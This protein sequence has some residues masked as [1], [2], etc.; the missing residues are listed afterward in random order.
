[1]V[2][3]ASA[4]LI[5][6]CAAT[7]NPN[8]THLPQTK[9]AATSSPETLPPSEE[10]VPAA[11]VQSVALRLLGALHAPCTVQLEMYELGNNALINALESTKRAGCILSVELDGTETQSQNSAR[12]LEQAGIRVEL[13]NLPGDALDHVKA[14]VLNDGQIALVGGVNWGAYSGDTT[15]AD[16]LLS[17]APGLSQKLASDWK[18]PDSFTGMVFP[19]VISGAE[20]QADFSS[21]INNAH[22]RILMV[23]NYASSYVVQDA[24]AAA[25]SRGVQVDV[26]LNPQGYGVQD[27]TKWLLAHGV[28]VRYAPPS[29]YLHAKVILSDNSGIIGSANFSHD[30]LNINR[31]LDVA[32]PN[33]VMPAA[34]AWAIALWNQGSSAA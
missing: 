16:V 15:D 31:E 8:P 34:T 30:G 13:T 18:H 27:A 7:P 6:G 3:L 14:L 17:N 23:A 26:L 5:A 32:I 10:W 12:I 9:P 11:Q 33:S 1:M 24:L 19:N 25:A 28:N 29:P 4:T 20:L 2:T 21:L 22:T